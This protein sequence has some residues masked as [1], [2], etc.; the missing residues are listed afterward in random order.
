MRIIAFLPFTLFILTGCA[1]VRPAKASVDST[2]VIIRDSIVFRDSI[3]MVQLP[4]E[5]AESRVP[6][7][8]TSVLETSIARSAAWIDNGI[9]F[10]TLQNK[11]EPLLPV[12]VKLPTRL[13]SEKGYAVRVQT[14]TV[15]VPRELT[16]WQTFSMVLGWIALAGILIFL[17]VRVIRKRLL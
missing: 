6:D 13:H 15:A 7:N 8:D 14:N 3:I 12:N 2:R 4:D 17:S 5:S 11:S 1:S 10:H 9:L 16:A